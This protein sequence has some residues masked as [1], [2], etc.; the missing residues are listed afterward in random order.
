MEN[1]HFP[2]DMENSHVGKDN[3]SI[4]PTYICSPVTSQ[5][6]NRYEVRIQPHPDRGIGGNVDDHV[7][8]G[9]GTPRSGMLRGFRLIQ[10]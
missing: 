7:W 5:P 2:P 9:N 1:S 10:P 6:K 8:C 3:E 4:Q